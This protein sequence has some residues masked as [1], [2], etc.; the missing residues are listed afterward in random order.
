MQ[1]LAII[2]VAPGLPRLDS[3]EELGRIGRMDDVTVLPLS[4]QV[5]RQDVARALRSRRW[6]VVLW[7]GHGAEGALLLSDGDMIRPPWLTSMM[8]GR[9]RIALL[10]VCGSGARP[11]SGAGLIASFSDLLPTVGVSLAA[12]MFAVEDRA[13]MAYDV[14]FVQA[15]VA[16]SSGW[17]AHQAALGAISGSA[18]VQAPQFFEGVGV[19]DF[20]GDGGRL[21]ALE[22]MVYEVTARQSVTEAL[23]KGVGEDVHELRAEVREVRTDVKALSLSSGRQQVALPREVLVL[24]ALAALM[25]LVILSFVAWRLI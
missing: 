3:L 7:I 20:T 14:A 18:M 4:G 11:A 17:Q 25:M 12:M 24:A 6:D 16:E 22:R 13:A 19:P 5:T 9:V 23:L 21:V 15:L 8:R 2:P 10:S 1:L